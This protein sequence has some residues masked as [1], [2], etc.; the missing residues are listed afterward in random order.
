MHF[1][2]VSVRGYMRLFQVYWKGGLNHSSSV[3]I[4]LEVDANVKISPKG[5]AV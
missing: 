4:D 5:P 1:S 2:S 3:V